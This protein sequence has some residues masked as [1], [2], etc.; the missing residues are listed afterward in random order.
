M[1]S[2]IVFGFVSGQL[3]LN[4]VCAQLR[5]QIEGDGQA[6]L[7]HILLQLQ[8]ELVAGDLLDQLARIDGVELHG[9]VKLVDVFVLFELSR[10]SC[11]RV[12]PV[13]FCWETTCD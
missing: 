9:E 12:E 5:R 3:T 2:I 4:D 11:I 10:E 13:L 8:I 1:I 6:A 7:Q